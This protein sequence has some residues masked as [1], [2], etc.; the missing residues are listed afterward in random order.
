[1]RPLE[2]SWP[3]ALRA[4]EA[5]HHE[6]C[7]AYGDRDYVQARSLHVEVLGAC[8]DADFLAGMGISL[9]ELALIDLAQG[10]ADGAWMRF[11]R[12]IACFE[13]GGQTHR[14]M[15]ARELWERAAAS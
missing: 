1:M 3:A 9:C 13:D 12:G 7:R 5:R 14:A 10:D 4:V 6:A 2:V 8:H 11:E 15:Q